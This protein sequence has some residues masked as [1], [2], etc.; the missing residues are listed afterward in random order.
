[1]ADQY[2][3]HLDNF[4]AH[5]DDLISQLRAKGSQQMFE[6]A[7]LRG[8]TRYTIPRSSASCSWRSPPPLPPSPSSCPLPRSSLSGTGRATDNGINHVVLER[9]LS[10]SFMSRRRRCCCCCRRS[11]QRR[12]RGLPPRWDERRCYRR[13]SYFLDCLFS[14]SALSFI[15]TFFVCIFVTAVDTKC[16][17][18]GESWCLF[19]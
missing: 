16:H 13:R 14:C 6:V 15:S 9:T 11:L 12:R 17:F 5:K 4:A 8:D 19:K 18:R 3:K 1:M 2:Q 10:S 7:S